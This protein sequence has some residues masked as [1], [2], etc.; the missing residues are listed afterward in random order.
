M[1]FPPLLGYKI[2]YAKVNYT[3]L[4]FKNCDKVY[5]VNYS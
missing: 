3:Q 2:S 4:D 1:F 5:C